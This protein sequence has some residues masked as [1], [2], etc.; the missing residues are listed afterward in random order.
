MTIAF[1]KKQSSFEAAIRAFDLEALRQLLVKDNAWPPSPMGLPPWVWVVD[2]AISRLT[3]QTGVRRTFP[4]KTVIAGLRGQLNLLSE[5]GQ[6][7][8]EKFIDDRH[9]TDHGGCVHR[10]LAF[11]SVRET[12]DMEALAQ[13]VIENVPE[14]ALTMRNQ[15]GNTARDLLDLMMASTQGAAYHNLPAFDR[16]WSAREAKNRLARA[17][18]TPVNSLPRVRHRP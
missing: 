16:A 3:D 9:E 17:S 10:L 12:P 15:A 8:S 13:C 7:A 11:G 2:N 14:I 4:L 18:E 1:T 6:D 5:S